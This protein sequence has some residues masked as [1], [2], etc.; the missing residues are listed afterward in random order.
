MDK[1]TLGKKGEAI[2]ERHLIQ[3][4]WT[5]LEHNWRYKRAEIDLIA[6]NTEGILIFIEVKTRSADYFGAPEEFVT[7][8]QQA[9]L[10]DAANRYMEAI[11]YDWEIRFDIISIVCP[12]NSSHQLKHLKDAFWAGLE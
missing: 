2:A 1:Q 5:I 8:A 12:S 6:K 11:D 3:L 4:G 10:I 9:R 7:A